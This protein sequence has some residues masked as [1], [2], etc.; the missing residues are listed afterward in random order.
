M[1]SAEGSSVELHAAPANEFHSLGC[2]YGAVR[3]MLTN[4]PPAIPL[5]APKVAGFRVNR[6]HLLRVF[7]SAVTVLTALI[8]ILFFSYA[9]VLS[10]LS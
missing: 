8:A 2:C 10:A 9:F 3:P 1:N 7:A 6:D 4:L 5:L